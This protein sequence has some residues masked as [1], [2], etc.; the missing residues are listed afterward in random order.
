MPKIVDWDARR[1]EVLEATWRVI[2]RD[3]LEKTT[4][5]RIAK[6][7]G[8]SHGIL[9]HYF[10]NKQDILASA[11][12]LTHQRVRDR[13]IR[14]TEGLAGL[15]AL[16]VAM[17]EALPLDAPRA[18]DAKIEVSFWHQ[19]LGNPDLARIQ[20]DEFERFW[21]R[22]HGLLEDAQGL[23]QLRRGLDIDQATH[24]LIILVDGISI[25]HV[26]YPKRMPPK[27]QVALLDAL[28]GSFRG[29]SED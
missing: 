6:E 16:R 10:S 13:I 15:E 11:I 29:M 23:G 7:A 22:L 18:L 5:R 27:R 24:E 20:A 9:S 2:A 1:D 17:L 14:K 21:S 3:G 25:Q 8:F 12:L 26:M 4:I 28:L 19:V